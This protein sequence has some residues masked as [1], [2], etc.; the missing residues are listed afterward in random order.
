MATGGVCLHVNLDQSHIAERLNLMSLTAQDIKRF[1]GSLSL[2]AQGLKAGELST[3]SLTKLSTE[4]GPIAYLSQR[5]LNGDPSLNTHRM[6]E[7]ADLYDEYLW[8]T[9]IA[10]HASRQGAQ[11]EEALYRSHATKTLLTA[12]S[13]ASPLASFIA[14]PIRWFRYS[15]RNRF[16]GI[17]MPKILLKLMFI[18]LMF[19]GTQQLLTP[20]L[21]P[22]ESLKLVSMGAWA[23][24]VQA[25]LS[26]QS[27]S[28]FSEHLSG[29]SLWLLALQRLW[30][31]WI[32]LSSFWVSRQRIAEAQLSSRM[33]VR[34]KRD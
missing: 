20:S 28:S 23:E 8:S 25:L 31:L 30:G 24:P 11:S 26:V 22:L 19:W 4:G 15:T 18:T 10:D 34:L 32:I 33:S 16:G 1:V 7:V 2:S 12:Y 9:M 13:V 27:K 5:T 14:G 29:S 6:S 21:N 17:C 3:A